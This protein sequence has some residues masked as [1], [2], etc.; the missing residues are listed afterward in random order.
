MER[1][2]LYLRGV[3]VCG[4]DARL[5]INQII[6]SLV[7]G[8]LL[9]SPSATKMHYFY[10]IYIIFT[11]WCSLC[12][13]ANRAMAEGWISSFFQKMKQ[14]CVDMTLSPSLISTLSLRSKTVSKSVETTFRGSLILFYN[15]CTNRGVP[16]RAKIILGYNKQPDNRIIFFSEAVIL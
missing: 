7:C 2:A 5:K 10:M 1:L 13:S 14:T 3:H 16:T 11:W 15:F 6:S 9:F 8:L 12:G 4:R